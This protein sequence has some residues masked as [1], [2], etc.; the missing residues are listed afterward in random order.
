MSIADFSRF[1][2]EQFKIFHWSN[3]IATPTYSWNLHLPMKLSFAND[4]EE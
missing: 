2:L 4:R 3:G 1:L